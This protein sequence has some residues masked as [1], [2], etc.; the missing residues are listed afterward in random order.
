M[1]GFI[2]HCNGL[3]GSTWSALKRL[4]LHNLCECVIAGVRH[5]RAIMLGAHANLPMC[6]V[7]YASLAAL[8]QHDV[9]VKFH[10]IVLYIMH[11]CTAGSVCL[12]SSAR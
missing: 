4:L 3:S 7:R 9:F 10:M 8:L 12:T 1:N 6:T 2:V 11:V 5:V